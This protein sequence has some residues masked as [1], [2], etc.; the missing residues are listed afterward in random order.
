[1]P[2]RRANHERDAF[3]NPITRPSV[4]SPSSAGGYAPP[5][6]TPAAPPA[7]AREPAPAPGSW[8]PPVAPDPDR[9]PSRDE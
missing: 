7:P 3:G 2:A 9:P 6:P 4:P 5:A 1:V 8:A